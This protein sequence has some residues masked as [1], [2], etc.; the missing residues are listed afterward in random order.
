MGAVTV[1][2]EDGERSAKGDEERGVAAT[3]EVVAGDVPAL[4][5]KSAEGGAN[6]ARQVVCAGLH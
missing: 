6:G 3:L 5:S 1:R 2:T 4:T